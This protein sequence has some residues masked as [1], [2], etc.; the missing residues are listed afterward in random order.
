MSQAFIIVFREGF[1]GFLI[2]AIILSYFKKTKDQ[3]LI[4]AVYWGLGISILAS[5]AMGYFLREG[6]NQ[7]LWEGILGLVTIVL[8]GSLVIQMWRI[9]PRFKSDVEQQLFKAS[10]KTSRA[11]AFLGVL[12]FSVI[13]ITREGMEMVV[14]LIQIRQ[15]QFVLGAL[16][17]LF[18]AIMLSL[19]WIRFS[20]LINLKRFFKVTG[21][22]LML[23]LVQIAIYSIHEFSE[24][25]ILPNSEVIHIATEQFSPVGLYGKWFSLLIVLP[26]VLWLIGGWISDRFFPKQA[27]QS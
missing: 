22:F 16:L 8:V 25:G 1:E 2:V 17:G 3:W 19:A 15:G 11:A 23:F 10:S 4:P 13:M 24:A 18:A 27:T 5:A 14:M 7:S 6:V 20:H 12:L 21:I 9:G 26:C